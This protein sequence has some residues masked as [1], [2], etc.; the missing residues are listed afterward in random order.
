MTHTQPFGTALVGQTEKALNAIL[1][2]Q[3]VGTGI[4]EPQWVTLTMTVVSGGTVDRAEL[5]GKVSGAT[6]F[7]EEAVTERIAEL[8]TAGFLTDGGEGR[9]QVTDEGRARWTEVRTALG[10]IIQ[11]L[12]GDLPEED[13][14][15][16]GRV[17]GT[18]LARANAVLTGA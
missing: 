18:V 1:E 3:L 12:W 6:Q 4:T 9:I 11:G 7:S 17:L 8:T 14:A 16:V 2:R 15:V 10:P 5:I 13:L